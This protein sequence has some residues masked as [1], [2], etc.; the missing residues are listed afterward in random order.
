MLKSAEEFLWI[1]HIGDR[2]AG[3][4][5]PSAFE[6]LIGPPS[7]TVNALDHFATRDKTWCWW[8][9]GLPKV[10]NGHRTPEHLQLPR[11]SGSTPERR[12][13][14]RTETE[15]QF[16]RDHVAAWNLEPWQHNAPRPAGET[17]KGF[18][19]DTRALKHNFSL[20]ASHYAPTVNAGALQ[21]AEPTMRYVIGVPIAFAGGP[22]TLVP[23]LNDIV[24]AVPYNAAKSI[25]HHYSL[26]TAFLPCDAT[27]YQANLTHVGKH[28]VTI[29]PSSSPPLH[30]AYTTSQRAAASDIPSTWCGMDALQDSPS[31]QYFASA[32]ARI[33]AAKGPTAFSG[34]LIGIWNNPRPVIQHRA[35]HSWEHTAAAN[36]SD[37]EWNDFIVTERA[38]AKE[39]A[40][41]LRAAGPHAAHF[42]AEVQSAADFEAELPRPEQGL[43]AYDNEIIRLAPTPPPPM[44]L[45][46]DYLSA[47]PPQH[48]PPGYEGITLQL[49]DLVKRWCRMDVATGITQQAQY[50][51]ECRLYGYATSIRPDFMAFGD[52]A[53][54]TLRYIDGNGGFLANIILWERTPS[55]YQALNL[56]TAIRDHK[57]KEVLMRVIGATSDQELLYFCL[58]GVRWMKQQPPRQIRFGRN[59]ESLATRV[60]PVG[61][62]TA[63]LLKAGL[64]SATKLRQAPNHDEQI[65]P[66]DPD[67]DNFLMFV[68]QFGM[69]CGG[70]DKPD[71][72]GEARKTGNSSDPPTSKTVHTREVR[73]E[74]RRDGQGE[75]VV[76]FNDLTGPKKI[77][78]D[79]DGPELS[80]PDKET[81]SRPRDLAAGAALMSYLAILGNTYV[82][83]IKDDFKW[84]FWQFYLHISQLWMSVEHIWVPFEAQNSEGTALTNEAG[85][86]TYE[87]WFCAVVPH[88]M[89]QGT[90]PA[91]KIACR[92]SEVFQEEWRG[93]MRREVV[94]AWLEQQTP[95]LQQALA[96]RR[97]H[98]P[99]HDCDPFVGYLYTD[100]FAKFFVGPLLGALGAQKWRQLLHDANVWVSA[101]TG[102]GTVIHSHG[103]RYV[104]N[105]G[106]TCL[107][108]NKHARGVAAAQQA[109]TTGV[110]RDELVAN[111]SFFV[112]VH[113]IANLKEGTLKGMWAPIKQPGVGTDTVV[114]T[115]QQHPRARQCYLSIVEQLRTRAS[116]SFYCAVADAHVEDPF[117][118]VRQTFSNA[119]SDACTDPVI[120]LPQ[121]V[122]WLDGC[123]WSFELQGEW[124]LR[125][126][127]VTEALGIAGNVL[128][129][130]ESAP[131]AALLLEG[132]ATAALA[133]IMGTTDS[134]DLQ[135]MNTRLK[136]T[137]TWKTVSATLWGIHS[138]GAGN[139]YADLGSRNRWDELA[140]LAAAFGIKLRKTKPTPEFENYAADVLANTTRFEH[141]AVEKQRLRARKH[142]TGP[143]LPV[144][145]Y[146]NGVEAIEFM[147]S[148]PRARSGIDTPPMFDSPTR[149]VTKHAQRREDR[150][151]PMLT[152]PDRLQH[153]AAAA[154]D[155]TTRTPPMLHADQSTSGQHC[156]LRCNKSADVLDEAWLRSKRHGT[157]RAVD[158]SEERQPATASAARKA[159]ALHDAELMVN[160]DTPYAICPSDPVRLRAMCVEASSSRI[161][162][163]PKGTQAAD[164]WG[165]GWA[166]RF[167]KE[168][169]TPWMR[170]R[171]VATE[172]ITREVHILAFMLMWWA[173][174]MR[175]ST[176]RAARGFTQAMPSSPMNAMYAYRRVLKDCGRF[177]APLSSAL[178][179][180]RSLRAQY[181]S[182]WGTQS[183]V[184][185]K[186]TP[187]A[188]H[189]IGKMLAGLTLLAMLGWSQTKHA[190]WIVLILY[191]LVTGTRNDEVAGE[192]TRLQRDSFVPYVDGIE[193][194]P[195]PQNW[196]RMR[197]GDHIRGKSAPSKCDRTNAHWGSKDMWF[198]LDDTNPQNFAAAWIQWEINHPCQV[199]QRKAWPA[200]SPKGDN[201]QFTT[202]M[203]HSDF[204]DIVTTLCG[205]DAHGNH[206]HDFRATLATKLVH[207]GQPDAVIQAV[208]R[209][210]TPDSIRTYAE[211][212]PSQYAA[213][214]EKAT[215]MRAPALEQARAIPEI[216]PAEACNRIDDT[217][218]QLEKAV[219]PKAPD[220]G[221]KS[222][223]QCTETAPASP[224]TTPVP[225][226]PATAT[227]RK[228][229]SKL[230]SKT[231]DL[232]ELGFIEGDT[233]T[234]RSAIGQRVSLPA[235]LWPGSPNKRSLCPCT[236]V[237]WA[238]S[239]SKYVI[240]SDDD[241]HHYA[242]PSKEVLRR[243]NAKRYL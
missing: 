242:V 128:M 167:G 20:F 142:N 40:E 180:L 225:I 240:K 111:N 53:F 28:I 68:P 185:R 156:A 126:I 47:I 223:N 160:D 38:R 168:H 104:L 113:D 25:E 37:T 43:P 63:K 30:V 19:Q 115:E 118:G 195:T 119:S 146:R 64:Y 71:A 88:V 170:P 120:G 132:D 106:F 129:F 215:Y 105:G 191:E 101:K 83:A 91:S 76:S 14:V 55:G 135:Y 157:S 224:A 84:F 133:M 152:P 1:N 186:H 24:F 56:E 79:Y 154:D 31:L 9:R 51:H 155:W 17:T 61:H 161:A 48:V 80:F 95:E 235:Y 122:G 114:L 36:G 42:A 107:I 171:V 202:R 3:E 46:T 59:V 73:K 8:T 58:H 151:P 183:L 236:V 66:I 60:A 72:P 33:Q 44:P 49:R 220:A 212:S 164:E 205:A 207:E 94:P 134:P 189:N 77:P 29:L 237:A 187:I 181:V 148:P 176:A 87:W 123:Y 10:P 201:T 86:T 103:G 21:E 54:V 173:I 7:F 90:R 165:F 26:L 199:S 127:T 241:G 116:A 228:K 131:A 35:S 174:Q 222:D 34:D 27:P 213:T 65:I 98:L 125:H 144:I 158:N 136:E 74:D 147:D 232:G 78:D 197:N 198:V 110:T 124:L 211:M 238:A 179:Q 92:F 100:D 102:A 231:Y 143:F 70:Q 177:L 200:F 12:M 192:D 121:V 182:T 5:P 150:T 109:L 188:D 69:G 39:F 190:A 184:P 159:A 2:S 75:R 15:L 99:P 18:D 239:L 50:D 32:I 85:E 227:S 117:T 214:V 163:I 62:A 67:L 178:S 112:H 210:K 153:G 41:H 11:R 226:A 172:F 45:C 204:K 81:K 208:L 4:Q 221:K 219:K 141:A 93:I 166:V 193:L 16:A 137:K 89:N 139:I 138:A 216:E 108:P 243:T 52:G 233:D 169:D 230:T 145:K 13:L 194:E 234:S 130:G 209:W 206:F 162:A 23:R 6:F 96:D 97:A 203:I 22:V 196:A 57:N 218:S 217:I 140:R 149:T 229:K 175:P 82:V